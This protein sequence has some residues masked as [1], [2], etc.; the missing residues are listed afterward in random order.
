MQPQD[1]QLQAGGK[2]WGFAATMAAVLV[3]VDVHSEILFDAAIA[4]IVAW[5][6]TLCLQ[7]GPRPP[8]VGLCSLF[9]APSSAKVQVQVCT[10]HRAA[11]ADPVDAMHAWCADLSRLS[12]LPSPPLQVKLRPAELSLRDLHLAAAKLQRCASADAIGGADVALGVQSLAQVL[13]QDKTLGAGRRTIALLT[14]R[15][16]P[17]DDFATFL[18][19]VKRSSQPPASLPALL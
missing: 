16:P 3:C 2:Q 4:A 19:V 5:G 13:A 10:M 14:D 18:E 17:A 8:R 12:T 11:T 9:R 7:E 1:N 6:D 15:L